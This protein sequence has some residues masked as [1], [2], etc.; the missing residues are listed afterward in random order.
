MIKLEIKEHKTK[1]YR[2]FVYLTPKFYREKIRQE[3]IY[4]GINEEKIDRFIGFTVVFS[5]LLAFVLAF[6]LWAFGFGL[7]GILV[8]AGLGGSFILIVNVIIGLI[9]DSRA[10][11]IE[12]L[13]PDALQLIAANV[14]AGM[15]MDKAIWLSARPEF[16]ILEDEIRRVGAKTFGGKSIKSALYEMKDRIKSETLDRTAKLIVEGM[17]SGG[18]IA[19][20]LDQTS[21]NIR[22]SQ[23]LKKEVATS[24]TMY[25]MFIIFAAV[26]G[27][28]LLYGISVYFVEVMNQLWGPQ[29]LASAEAFQG[30]ALAKVTGPQ[31]TSNELLYFAIAAIFVTTL[32]GSLTLGLIKYGEEK[33]GIRYIPALILGGL[34]VFFMVRIVIGYFFGSLFLL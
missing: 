19:Q 6:N 23:A 18:E 17:E 30:K 22:T 12:N 34:G 1:R 20:L 14:R 15:T 25:G 13:L 31:I 26:L 27:A 5:I 9:A 33:R 10:R 28:P 8:G 24:V 11:E 32:F 7:L 21:L 16:G 2:R 4:A 3:M 29:V